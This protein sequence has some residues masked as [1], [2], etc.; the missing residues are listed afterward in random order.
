MKKATCDPEKLVLERAFEEGASF[1]I[2]RK[3]MDKKTRRKLL[4]KR[5]KRSK[6][7]LR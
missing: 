5:K 1:L 4:K 7:S 3:E 2:E 6:R